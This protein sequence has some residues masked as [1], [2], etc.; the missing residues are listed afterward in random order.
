[1]QFRAF[2]MFKLRLTLLE[3]PPSS[4][5]VAGV[6]GGARIF[7]YFPDRHRILGKVKKFHSKI[8]SG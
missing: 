8:P 5:K 1:M 4:A 6:T 7:F 3:F 2:F